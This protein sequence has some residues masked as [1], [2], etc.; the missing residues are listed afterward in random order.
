V[1]QTNQPGPVNLTEAASRMPWSEVGEA[2]RISAHLASTI[3]EIRA[4]SYAE[5]GHPYDGSADS[6]YVIVSGYGALRQGEARLECTGGDLVY[7][8]SGCPH[9]FERMDGEIRAWRISLTPAKASI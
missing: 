5:D 3:L 2:L 6:I 4:L 9:Q 8:P 1:P 7:M